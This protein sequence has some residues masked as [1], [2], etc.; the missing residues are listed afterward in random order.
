MGRLRNV[1]LLTKFAI[2]SFLVLAALG[3]AL[4]YFISRY[5]EE[6]IFSN[7]ANIAVPTQNRLITPEL[8][9]GDFRGGTKKL[10]NRKFNNFLRKR[11]FSK[12]IVFVK[13]WRRDGTV[14]WTNKKLGIGRRFSPKPALRKA[15]EGNVEYERTDLSNVENILERPKHNELLEIYTPIRLNGRI[16]GAY[17]V[18]YSLDPVLAA[19]NRIRRYISLTISAVLTILFL[20]Q[21]GIVRSASNTIVRQ[22]VDLRQLSDELAASFEQLKAHYLGTLVSLDR[23]LDARDKIT[24]AHSARLKAIAHKIGARL[25]LSPDAHRRIEYGS[26][27]HDLGKIGIPEHILQKPQR[28]TPEEMAEMRK[29]PWIGAEIIRS[30]PFLTD[31]ADIVEHHHERFDGKGY[32]NGLAGNDIPVEARILSVIDAYDAM[33]HNRPYRAALPIDAAV[34]EL[35]KESGTQFDP[36][37]ISI[38]LRYLAADEGVELPPE[39]E[40]ELRRAA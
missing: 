39:A 10:D 40:E 25:N 33:T 1:S 34:R 27:L 12:E 21:F 31:T 14:L 23:A 32:P 37:I 30:V 3:A 6:T 18:Y 15:L 20:V 13:I 5:V 36:E 17:E 11:V 35:V 38:F 29:H 19:I 8:K 7:F 2:S 22:N 24:G 26:Q 4:N 28:L 16:V 9:P